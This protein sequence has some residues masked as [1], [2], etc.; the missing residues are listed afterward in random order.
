[1]PTE[2]VTLNIY[3]SGKSPT[4]APWTA[5]ALAASPGHDRCARE[6]VASL[7]RGAPAY[8]VVVDIPADVF[9]V[10]EAIVVE[11]GAVEVVK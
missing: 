3:L 8:R 2:T 4:G 6:S 1:M 10:P 9:D 5:V 11:A 7:S